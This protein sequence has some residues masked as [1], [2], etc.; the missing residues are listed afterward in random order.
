MAR[1]TVVV[2]LLA[3]L[4]AGLAHAHKYY[5]ALTRI[6]Y[7]ERA[8]TFEVVHRFFAH[9]LERA[10]AQRAGHGVSMADIRGVEAVAGPIIGA[11]FSLKADGAPVV[12][13]FLGLE[14]DG[15]FAWS[16]F[17]GEASSSPKSLE[18]ANRLLIGAFA[19]QI[20]TVTADIGGIVRSANFR[21]GEETAKLE[22]SPPDRKED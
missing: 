21:S 9:D 7:N 20:N 14:L 17:E 3:I 2:A 13:K 11:E 15:D 8:G 16:Y 4:G 5:A 6:S 19:D 12:L 1:F 18:I 10:L 22:F